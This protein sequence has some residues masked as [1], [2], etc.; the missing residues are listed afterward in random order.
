[1]TRAAGLVL[2]AMGL[3]QWLRAPGHAHT[4]HRHD[5]P[6]GEGTARERTGLLG[7]AAF[8]FVLG[9]AHEEE[10]AVLALCAGRTSCWGVMTVYAL[11]VAGVI[12]ALTLVSVATFERFHH[13]VEGWHDRLPRISAAILVEIGLLYLLGVM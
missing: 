2:V 11:A 6:P 13:R 4:G 7:L 8:A 9:F 5:L 10:F 1:M 3:V 12:L